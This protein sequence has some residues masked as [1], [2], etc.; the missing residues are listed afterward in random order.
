MYVG[1]KKAFIFRSTK[2][3]GWLDLLKITS[4]LQEFYVKADI[5]DIHFK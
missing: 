1:I 2:T 4:N 3:N 5:K